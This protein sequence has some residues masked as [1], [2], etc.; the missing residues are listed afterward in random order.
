MAFSSAVI[1]AA[2]QRSGGRCECCRTTCGHGYYR[3]NR[4]LNWYARGNDYAAD[5]WEAHHVIAVEYGG[6][7]TLENCRILCI[8]CHK[9]TPTYG[10]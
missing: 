9:K 8:P 3:C 2:W 1:A 4:A 6:P 5:G 10:R 7:D